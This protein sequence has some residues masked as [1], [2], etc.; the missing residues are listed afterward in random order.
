VAEN[1]TAAK[2]ASWRT[3]SRLEAGILIVVTLQRWYRRMKKG[4]RKLKHGIRIKP[5]SGRKIAASA[6]HFGGSL[7]HTL[8][9]NA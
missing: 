7:L 1:P 8:E 6:F 9:V 5:T 4:C 3:S 2:A